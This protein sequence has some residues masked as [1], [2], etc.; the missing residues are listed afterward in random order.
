MK[1]RNAALIPRYETSLTEL[2]AVFA[3]SGGHGTVLTPN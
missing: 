3:S 2:K 1:Y